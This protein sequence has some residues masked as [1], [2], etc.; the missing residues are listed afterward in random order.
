MNKD[1]DAVLDYGHDWSA[2]LIDGDQIAASTWIVPTGIT[3]ESDSH[4]ATTTT[5]WLSGGELDKRYFLVNRVTTTAG[6]TD[7]RTLQI[8]ITNR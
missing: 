7:D 3:K 6:R 2:W 4:D 8:N 5:V 1:P